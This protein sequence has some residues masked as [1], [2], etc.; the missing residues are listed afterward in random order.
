GYTGEAG[1]E[2]YCEAENAGHV[3]DSLL[4]AGRD[5]GLLPAGL[6]ARDT[7]RIEAGYNL[8]GNDI[9]EST[10][11]LEAGLGWITKL[12]KDNFI[13]KAALEE[14][15]RKGLERK[16]IGFVLQERAIPRQGYPIHD[17]DGRDIGVVTSGTQSP[18]LKQGIGL[19]YVRNESRF[20][21][22]GAEIMILIRGKASLAIVQ[23]PPFHKK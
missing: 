21:E 13:G 7:L 12:E 3:W 22:P 6:G 10:N 1:V 14:I 20:T 2:I 18:V 17:T 15:K 4:E 16:L 9:T 23:K 19:G 5:K 11:P 8:Y